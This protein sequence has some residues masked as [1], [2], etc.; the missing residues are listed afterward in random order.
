MSYIMHLPCASCL[1]PPP[2][3]R[4]PSSPCCHLQCRAHRALA[5]PGPAT[6]VRPW[7]LSCPAPPLHLPLSPPPCHPVHRPAS[8]SSSSSCSAPRMASR[9]SGRRT[10]TA[11]CARPPSTTVRTA[12]HTE[13]G[14]RGTRYMAGAQAALHGAPQCP[15]CPA[16]PPSFCFQMQ[17]RSPACPSSWAPSPPSCPA[18]WACER[19]TAQQGAAGHSRHS[20]AQCGME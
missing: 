2:L 19:S 11:C 15:N 4:L 9:L 5:A 20:R 10:S 3:H 17:A 7:L 8:R 13:E 16:A 18:T 1:P 12:L 14:S 6:H